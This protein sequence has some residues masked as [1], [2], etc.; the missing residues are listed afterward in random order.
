MSA[1]EPTVFKFIGHAC[2]LATYQGKSIL[3][4]PWFGGPIN[5]GLFEGYP[6]F[7]ALTE[8]EIGSLVGIHISHIHYD[9]CSKADLE[10][11]P[12]K[13]P[14]Y[15]GRYHDRD[16]Y[17]FVADMGFKVIEIDAASEGCAIGPFRL[18][19]IRKTP[20]D[21]SFDSA[22]VLQAGDE[23]F[24]LNNDCLL[25]DFHYNLIH[26]IYGDFT[27]AFL[28]YASANPF[29]WNSDFSRAEGF[30]SPLS[31]DESTKN[32]QATTWRH[33][34]RVADA[35]RLKW[36]VPYASSYRFTSR[37][38][39]Q[40]NRHFG[41]A[42]EIYEYDLGRTRPLVLH[43]G[44]TLRSDLTGTIPNHREKSSPLVP[45]AALRPPFLQTE[46]S[47]SERA[48]IAKKSQSFFLELF[49]RQTRHWLEP[50][51]IDIVLVSSGVET[52]LRYGFDGETVSEAVSS[53]PPLD[54]AD[55]QMKLPL[56]IAQGLCDRKLTLENAYFHFCFEV[57]WRRVKF[58]QMYFIGWR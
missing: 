8:D 50:M 13:I 48:E 49:L 32:R 24:Y 10:K 36:A 45:D 41:V 57:E 2:V 39:A 38:F 21:R 14:I 19:V 22:C 43:H 15:I 28:G 27:G 52:T 40:L 53:S 56:A 25:T 16:L 20:E 33:V 31:L 26:H 44:E 35:L 17:T 37:D 9:H 12:R 6:K 47:N 46:F 55:V 5:F 11:L 58:G 4:D 18:S 54:E 1:V 7:G 42:E 3:F 23:R 29:T 30:S 34:A 51:S